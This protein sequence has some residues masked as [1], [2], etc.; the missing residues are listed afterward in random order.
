M[1]NS[2]M[3]YNGK[4]YTI[5]DKLQPQLDNKTVSERY[6]ILTLF[7]IGKEL[8]HE[9]AT[10][11]MALLPGMLIDVRLLIGL[12]IGH[13]KENGSA[14][15][16]YFK[17]SEPVTFEID[18]KKHTITISDVKY[19]PQGIAAVYSQ[20]SEVC[21]SKRVTIVDIG[22]Q[23]VDY[24]RM[25]DLVPNPEMSGHFDQGVNILF[26]RI[27][28]Y[29]RSKVTKNIPIDII[30]GVLLKDPQT[31][32]ESSTKRIKII[33]E[34]TRQHAN[35]LIESLS[36]I[37][38]DFENDHVVFMGGGSALLKDYVTELG[39][40]ERPLWLC[41][42]KANVKGYKVLYNTQARRKLV[43]SQ[44]LNLAGGAG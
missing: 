17:R 16:K 6:F 5:V 15:V 39:I 22:G 33:S 25:V 31:L 3:K 29:A 35:A 42:V 14:Y 28:L 1:G 2:T 4:E 32:D 36:H 43:E 20:S 11:R 24:A 8:E 34:A 44:K 12:P 10:N 21:D 13:F 27:N 19:Y 7:A 41:D 9:S 30:E 40:V 23:T 18:G 37:G 38:V 26:D